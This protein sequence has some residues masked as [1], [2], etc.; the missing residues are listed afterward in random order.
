MPTP[1][2]LMPN[3][4]PYPPADPP[5]P[6]AL[7]R[8]ASWAGQAR[9][10]LA[11]PLY[12]GVARPPPV[13]WLPALLI[14]AL[15]L[16]GPAYLALRTIS[17]GPD[18][19]E[20]IFRTRTLWIALRTLS[21]MAAVMIGCIAVATPIAWLTVRTN[22]P[23]AAF[24]R[25]ATM[26]PLTLP[27]Y[28]VGFTVAIGL[29]PRGILQGWLEA[30]FGVERLPS[31]YGFS[32]AAF[33]LIIISFPYVLLP[34]RAALWN[35][36]ASL[37]E[38]ARALG[39]NRRQAFFRVTVPM[40][41]PAI[42]AGGLLVALYTLSDFGA[43][44]MLRY[45]TFT[46]S[47]FIQYQA[48]LDRT[49]AAAWSLALMVLALSVV[50][51]EH[52]ARGRMRYYRS[53]GGAAR[54]PET[55]PLGPWRWPALAY[56]ALVVIIS[57]GLPLSVLAYW[58][59]R[60]ALAGETLP[61]LWPAAAN[62]IGV[63]VMAALLTTLCAAPIA[64]LSVR[65]PGRFSRW[66]ERLGFVGFALPGLV[67]ALGL[68]Y[69]GA[70]YAP[71]LYQS[72]AMLAVAYVTLF[73][74]AAVGSLRASLVQVRP[75]LEEAAR[76]LGKGPLATLLAVTLPLV[77]PGLFS[78]AALVFLLTMKELP[79]TL[80]LS[81]IGFTT[82]ASAIWSAANEAFFARAAAPALLLVA[83]SAIPLSVLTIREERARR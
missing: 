64:M 67:I 33:T 54:L 83:V 50:W 6:P 42:L 53:R 13:V 41:R 66:L 55:V 28:I 31:I 47:I 27:S 57:L 52:A 18:A 71:W 37:E 23:G 48:A 51:A 72:L 14:A 60:G 19:A 82:L 34:L 4:R 58:T 22:L 56:C 75:E 17:A 24:W 80:I 70:N 25:V 5:P 3:P 59:V 73:L 12:D 78:G 76:S 30:A 65:Y 2:S 69:F 9:R 26:L 7:L 49:L 45:E 35:L 46:W 32:G 15:L 77:R 1:A 21:L 44:A 10:T 79:A 16:L 11:R 38:S 43:V 29:G 81:P 74:P 61:I 20:L 39:H 36:D 68:V 8:A 63:S 62:S 40:L